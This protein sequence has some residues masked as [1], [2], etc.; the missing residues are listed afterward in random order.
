M[1]LWRQAISVATVFL[2]L[3]AFVWRLQRR[4][5]AGRQWSLKRPLPLPWGTGILLLGGLRKRAGDEASQREIPPLESLARV[6]LTPQHSLHWVRA[7][8]C[9]LLVATHPQGCILLTRIRGRRSSL[10]EG[11]GA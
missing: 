3:G 10:R 2:L 7:G 6:A 9:D 1:E 5:A 4:K 8:D 11:A